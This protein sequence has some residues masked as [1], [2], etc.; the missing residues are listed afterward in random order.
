[1]KK[2]LSVTKISQRSVT[3]S[4]PSATKTTARSKSNHG[5]TAASEKSNGKAKRRSNTFPIVAIGASAGGL[6]AITELLRNL[7]PTTGMAYVYIQHLDPAHKSMLSSILAKETKMKVVEAKEK[8]KLEPNHVY[9]IPPN[10][11]MIIVDGSLK[12]NT[13]PAKPIVHMP[14]NHFFV[15]LAGKRKEGAIGIVLSGNANDGALGLK[16]IKSAGGVTFAQD[17]SA[18]FQSMPKSAI[19]E[20]AVDL[21]LSPRQI[22]KEL[23]HLAKNQEVLKHTM[24]DGDGGVE[25]SE[26]ELQDI[27]ALLNRTTGVDFSHYKETTIRRRIV[28]R[29]LLNKLHGLKEY[30]SYLKKKNDEANALYQDLLIHVTGFFRDADTMEFVRKEV[31]PRILKTKTANDPIRIWIPACS[32]GEEAYSLAILLMEALSEKITNPT[33]QIFATDLSEAAIAKARAGIYTKAELADVSSKR[34]QKFFTVIDGNYRISKSIRDLC[35][36]APHNVFKDPPFARLDLIS[37][38]NLMIYLDSHL[39]K[40][41]IATFHY[42][43]K[44]NG[45]LVLGKSENISASPNLFTPLDKKVRVFIRKKN[46]DERAKFE[47]MYH[48]T[49]KRAVPVAKREVVREEARTERTKRPAME[50]TVD[51]ILLNHYTP[52]C[53][54]VNEN[55]DIIQFRGSIGLF[56]EPAPG[57]ASLSLLRMARNGLGFELRNLVHKAMKSGKQVKKSGIEMQHRGASHNVSI[58]VVPMNGDDEKNYL[59]LFEEI[60]VPL[61]S[62][63]TSGTSRN[64]KIKQLEQELF[65]AREDIRSLSEEQEAANEELQSA[66]EEV[67]SSNEELQSMNEELEI[68]KEEIESANEE[69]TTMN[70]ELQVRNEQLN[71]LFE[72]NEAIIFTI[73][74]GVIILDDHLRVISANPSFYKIFHVTEEETMGKMLFDLGN[75][76]WNIPKLRQLLEEIIPNNQQFLGFEV[77]HTFPDIGKK[78]MVLNAKRLVQKTQQKH[79]IFLAIEDATEQV[80]KREIEAREKWLEEM[81]NQA[82]VMIWRSDEKGRRN[83]FNKTW[84]EFTGKTLED[85]MGTGWQQDGHPDDREQWIKHYND[86]FRKKVAYT[87]EFRLRRFDG[88]Y[89]W[90]MVTG[91][92][93]YDEHKTFSGFIGT[94]ID[95]HDKK[96]AEE[97]LE[98]S[99]KKT[100]NILESLPQIAFTMSPDRSTDYFNDAWY[101][102]TGEDRAHPFTPGQRRKLGHPSDEKMRDTWKKKFEAGESYE[103]EYRIRGK[104]GEYRWF[105]T[106][107]SPIKNAKGEITQWIGSSTDIDEQKKLNEEIQNLLSKEKFAR[108]QTEAERK[109]MH[110]FFMNLPAAVSI[111]TGPEHVFEFTNIA[112][113]QFIKTKGNIIGKSVKDVYPEMESQGTLKLL[114]EVY[115]S[116]QPFEVKEMMIQVELEEKGK[117]KE[118]YYDYTLHPYRDEKGNIE[119]IISFTIDVTEQAQAR[120]A[121]EESSNII[122]NIL[123]GLPQMA[124]MSDAKGNRNFFNKTWLE[125]TGRTL[126]E[127]KGMGWLDLMN[128]VDRQR[129]LGV[130]N[131]ALKNETAY[132]AEYRL[133]RYD[134][135]YRWMLSSAKPNYDENGKFLGFIGSVTDIHDRIMAEEILK[136]S[137][138][139][140]RNVLESLP[141]IAFTTLPDGSVT[142]SNDAWYEYTGDNREH[143]F[144]GEERR[145]L[146]HP[147]DLPVLRRWL[148]SLEAG[149]PFEGE[150]RIRRRDGE[151]RWFLTRIVPVK[152]AE[153]NI[154]Q[155]IGTSTDVHEQKMFS[156]E[157]ER[158]VKKRTADL[159]TA[160]FNLERSNKELQEFAF[161]ASHD[162]QEPLRKIQTFID[163]LTKQYKDELPETSLEYFNRII[164][165]A[166]RMRQLIDD[167][168]NLSRASVDGKSFVVTDLNQVMQEAISSYDLK[169]GQMN[170]QVQ[171]ETLPAI[172]AIPA[173]M[174][175]LFENLL[176][177]SLKFTEA[178]IPLVTVKSHKLSE[179]EIRNRHG[180]YE[181]NTWY[182]ITFTDNGIGFDQKFADQIFV[183]FQRLH[184]TVKY[185]GTGIGLA[186]CKK[187]VL[188]HGGEIYAESKENDGTTFYILLPEKQ[189][190]KMQKN[191]IDLSTS[192]Y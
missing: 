127:D 116:G 137:E 12:L 2:K 114:D 14:I 140:I 90:V 157:L 152:N 50:E 162:L 142:Y 64:K 184:D 84:L 117:L 73:R 85:E 42:A 37:C 47:M 179:G 177:N 132:S 58:E 118:G 31:L 110:D 10:K 187:I 151:F 119:G 169:I 99:E 81:A 70:Q 192:S 148:K 56:L 60:P 126:E 101:E 144:A 136:E 69:L 106:R 165:A 86:A 145:K 36:F 7:S 76:Q 11:D 124:W 155:W 181:N 185:P 135:E 72:F 115:A 96:M 28:R 78:I 79:L 75:G 133:R 95:I 186:L 147:D 183:T 26:D 82:P 173:Q 168:L 55:L 23:G 21:V 34:L 63:D 65:I 18:K 93:I 83:F 128:P 20:G 3:N 123:E 9:V 80:K 107:I 39:Q 49:E 59:I 158:A 27:L 71:E 120:R 175:Q 94:V 1:M 6:E 104:D 143:P 146:G 149:E 139:R 156:K 129:F 74:E 180:L 92:P 122:L 51:E 103:G 91:K 112:S 176:S 98:Q 105:L 15:S 141:Q 87:D 166:N 30:E 35:V 121:V 97:V 32:T 4:S 134:G 188:N 170:A 57:K 164:N 48:L 161:A 25:E 191:E 130:Y 77:H 45:Y 88:E 40:K 13:R 8:M 68:S 190:E 108:A 131:T 33:V 167:L 113:R 172:E 111:M 153:G 150:G 46:G 159:N 178:S 89:R 22:A 19:A 160:N 163:R 17:K 66:N 100:R 44:S 102:Y 61:I 41:L 43:L 154:V 67:V 53:V 52:A 109:K 5:S 54:V 171:Y 182:E 138:K 38:C 189:I 24:G 174:K 16:A 29:M 125:F 62:S